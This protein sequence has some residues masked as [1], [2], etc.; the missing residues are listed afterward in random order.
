[1][2]LTGIYVWSTCSFGVR[3]S[4]LTNRGIITEGPYRYFKHPAYLSKNIAWW[5]MSVPFISQH[6]IL[7]AI[8]ACICLLLTNLIYGIRAWTEERHLL[9]DPAYQT[10][11]AWME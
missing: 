1:M 9:R 10:Y 2:V 11:Y 3:F 5:M 6:N 8:R 4:N 7:D